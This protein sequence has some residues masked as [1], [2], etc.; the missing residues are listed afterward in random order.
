MSDFCEKHDSD[1]RLHAADGGSGEATNAFYDDGCTLDVDHPLNGITSV[2]TKVVACAPSVNKSAYWL[3]THA[4]DAINA[5]IKSW[6]ESQKITLH[7]ASKASASGTVAVWGLRCESCFNAYGTEAQRNQV[8]PANRPELDTLNS[9]AS[10]TGALTRKKNKWVKHINV[11]CHK[12]LVQL[13]QV[14]A[15]ESGIVQ[16]STAVS[17]RITSAMRCLFRMVLYIAQNR[18]PLS[19]VNDLRQ[20]HVLNGNPDMSLDPKRGVLADPSANYSSEQV[21]Q[22]MLEIAAHVCNLETAALLKRARVVALTLDE[23][24]CSGNLPQLL[25][26]AHMLAS[27][28]TDAEM[29]APVYRLLTCKQLS[30][31]PEAAIAL[32]RELK[33][34]DKI[35]SELEKPGG[36]ALKG[37]LNMVRAVHDVSTGPRFSGEFSLAKV[38]GVA[39]DGTGSN[40]GVHRGVFP[41]LT[42]CVKKSGGRVKPLLNVCTP[43]KLALVMSD[44]SAEVSFLH[45]EFQPDIE[46]LFRFINNSAVRN[47]AMSEAFKE[48]GLQEVAMICAFFTRWLSHGRCV[49]NL[50]KGLPGLLAG[51]RTIAENKTDV[52]CALA[53]GLLYKW[54]S[55]RHLAAVALML[56]VFEP[57]DIYKKQLQSREQTHAQNMAHYHACRASLVQMPADVFSSPALLQFVDLLK[58]GAISSA[59]C[60]ELDRIDRQ[61]SEQF[62]TW[63]GDQLISFQQVVRFPFISAILRGLSTRIMDE[64]M[65][66]LCALDRISLP[67]D[68]LEMIGRFSEYKTRACRLLKRQ[69]KERALAAARE[70]VAMLSAALQIEE[71]EAHAEQKQE[72]QGH[73]P[74]EGVVNTE[75]PAFQFRVPETVAAETAFEKDLK[76]VTERLDLSSSDGARLKA[77][78]VTWRS[79]LLDAQYQLL[80]AGSSH[81]LKTVLDVHK[82]VLFRVNSRSV[83]SV[84]PLHTLL[85]DISATNL[86]VSVEP[87]RGFSFMNGTKTVLRANLEEKQLDN[88]MI[89]GLHSPSLASADASAIESCKLSVFLDAC[90][91]RWDS[92]KARRCRSALYNDDPDKKAILKPRA[93]R[94]R[95]GLLENNGFAKL[96]KLEEDGKAADKG[97]SS[98]SSEAHSAL[99]SALPDSAGLAK[100]AHS[101]RGDAVAGEMLSVSLLC[102]INTFYLMCVGDKPSR[103][104]QL[105]MKQKELSMY[106]NMTVDAAQSRS[107]QKKACVAEQRKAKGKGKDA[108]KRAAKQPAAVREDARWLDTVERQDKRAATEGKFLSVVPPTRPGG[109]TRKAVVSSTA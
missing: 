72:R 34:D 81:L 88:L 107:D 49:V 32:A 58:T 67:V 73:A 74:P 85:L 60:R 18:R 11:P 95:Q 83:Q 2:D 37:G 77:E 68:V 41:L 102:H 31:D 96:A 99:S 21:L 98:A 8:P 52:D 100:E 86:E 36:V 43:H 10:A 105:I 104:K 14:D 47:T 76:L 82:C 20:L 64:T 56:D 54:G 9:W 59:D 55:F 93:K 109:R 28:E 4:K 16:Q 24:T 33:L 69:Q 22:E 25:L 12:N 6:P 92:L 3:A 89:V 29:K 75:I 1:G 40:T 71:E 106:F 61:N 38:A 108:K 23:S 44:A 65:E 19:D 90:M 80:Q 26:Y 48:L 66:T 97:A 91:T 13:P 78:H 46:A 84:F 62:D 70:R 35:L 79:F 101:E 5:V 27:I 51:L 42:K 7:L 39:A 17:G 15:A 30:P 87:E 50:H 53:S 57:V 103:P 45:K 63:L 94:S